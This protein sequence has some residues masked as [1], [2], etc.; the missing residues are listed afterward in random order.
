MQKNA[1]ELK[2]KKVTEKVAFLGFVVLAPLEQ[3]F[4]RKN[5]WNF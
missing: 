4:T 1:A 5:A 3:F 2:G